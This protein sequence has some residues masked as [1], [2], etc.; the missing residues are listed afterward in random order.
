MAILLNWNNLY[1]IKNP[2]LVLM[3]EKLSRTMMKIE[4]EM[5]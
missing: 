4:A 5:I 3:C 1:M 2:L